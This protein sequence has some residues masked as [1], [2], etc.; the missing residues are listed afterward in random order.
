LAF[1]I[2]AFWKELTLAMVCVGIGI[3][4]MA[5][6]IA[7][8]FIGWGSLILSLWA[9][10]ICVSVWDDIKK[11]RKKREE[12]RMSANDPKREP[13]RTMVRKQTDSTVPL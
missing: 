2:V 9:V 7:T 6:Y 1:W 10:M 4:A 5:A 8:Y 3:L 12:E 13:N 11:K